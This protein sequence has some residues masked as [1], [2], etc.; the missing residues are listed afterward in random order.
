LNKLVEFLNKNPTLVIEIGGHTDNVGNDQANMLLSENRA[1]SV[2]DF[3]VAKGIIVTRLQAKG[4][5]ETIPKGDNS[6]E[7]GREENRRTEFRIVKK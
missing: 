5:G 3:L 1:K 6:T 7:K 4:Y 2:V